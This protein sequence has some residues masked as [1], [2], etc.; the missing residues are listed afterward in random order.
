[1]PPTLSESSESENV[2]MQET[3]AERMLRLQGWT[4]GKKQITSQASANPEKISANPENTDNTFGKYIQTFKYGQLPFEN[5]YKHLKMN[6]FSFAHFC[7][8]N[9]HF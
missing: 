6:N 1:M 8:K 4:E 7:F 5:I 3:F 9:S 2:S